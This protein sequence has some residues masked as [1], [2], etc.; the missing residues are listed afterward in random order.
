MKTICIFVGCLALALLS[1]GCQNTKTRA[2]EGTVIGGVLGAAAGGIIGHQGHHAGEG[3]AIGAAAG[4]VTGAIVGSQIDKPAQSS[5]AQAAATQSTQSAQ[6]VNPNQITIQQIVDLAKQGINE[7]VII[8]KIRLSNS[9]FSL[10]PDDV[11]YLKK[12]GVSQRVI[13]VMQNG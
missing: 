7:N 11:D 4:A 12:Q 6:A 9:K 10:T 1:T 3:L 5:P 2:G 13:D 8:D